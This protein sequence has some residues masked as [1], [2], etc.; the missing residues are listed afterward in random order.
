MAGPLAGAG[1]SLLLVLVGLGLTSA[2][3]GTI[4]V[5]PAAF[6]DSLLLATLGE[7]P[8]FAACRLHKDRHPVVSMRHEPGRAP[9]GWSS[10]LFNS[11]A[12]QTFAAATRDDCRQAVPG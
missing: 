11:I 8:M 12:M 10:Q 5:E 3:V 7:P 6:E 2:G 9:S 4:P 1:L